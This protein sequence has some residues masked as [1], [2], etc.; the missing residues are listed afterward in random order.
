[1]GLPLRIRHIHHRGTEGTEKNK[2]REEERK[3]IHKVTA[4]LP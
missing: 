3:T 4:E 2:T 1:M